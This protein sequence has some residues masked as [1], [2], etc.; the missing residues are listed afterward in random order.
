MFLVAL[1]TIVAV[2]LWGQQPLVVK[3]PYG[4]FTFDATVTNE[5]YLGHKLNGTIVNNTTKD[6]LSLEFVLVYYD[7]SGNKVDA[8]VGD[9]VRVPELKKGASYSIGS[10]YGETILGRAAR[11]REAPIVRYEA[12]FKDG[13]VQAAYAFAL[14]K[15]SLAKTG[16]PTFTESTELESSDDLADF[17]FSISKQQFS[18]VLKNKTDEPMDIDWNKVAFVDIGGESHKVMHSGVKY[19][20]R[21]EPLAPTTVPPSAKLEDIVFPADYVYYSEGEYGGWRELPL[22]PDGEKALALKGQTFSVFMPI[23]VNGTVK[24]YSFKFKVADVVL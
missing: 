14:V 4:E 12:S 16:K 19:I 3:T 21:N 11:G 18:F 7:A 15:K 22:F 10:G 23:R 5:K 24:N 6:W 2:G 8:I 1:I 9:T 13:T 17:T 20:A